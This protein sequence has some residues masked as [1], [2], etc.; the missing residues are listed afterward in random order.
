LLPAFT[1][2]M[3][4]QGQVRAFAV[5]FVLASFLAGLTGCRQVPRLESSDRGLAAPV[6]DLSADEAAGGHTL[7][8]HVGKSDADLLERLAREPEISAASTY[9]DRETAER[10]V[11]RVLQQEHMR[12]ERWLQRPG[13]HPNL[14][15]DYRGDSSRPI[16]RMLRRGSRLAD[17]C[18][19]AIVVLRWDG[20]QQY[21]VLT[22]YPESR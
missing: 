18:S 14:A 12:I 7:K 15:L 9:R 1:S 20:G 19:D 2:I 11:G 17:P 5:G 16:G 13:Q 10:V 21:H 3:G 6:H 8:Q 4:L 22:S